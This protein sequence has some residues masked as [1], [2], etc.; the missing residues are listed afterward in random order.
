MIAAA[1][2]LVIVLS[3]GGHWF[4]G[5]PQ[6]IRIEW[7]VE[8]PIANAEFVWSLECEQTALATGRLAM[9][10]DRRP[11][12]LTM[13][14]PKVRVQTPMTLAYHVERKDS[15]KPLAEGTIA[16]QLYPEDLL[17]HTAKR[18]AGKRLFVWDR[19]D[20]LPT[21]LKRVAIEHTL[22]TRATQL[23]FASPGILIVGL[24]QLGSDTFDQSSLMSFAGAGTSVLVLNQTQPSSL[25]GYPLARRAAPSKLAWQET[26]SLSRALQRFEPS[27]T[28]SEL[29][30]I[31]LPADEPVLE[32]AWWPRE[33]PSP[34]PASIDALVATKAVGNGRLV[35]CQLPLGDWNADP[36][37]HLFLADALDYLASRAEATPSPSHRTRPPEPAPSPKT[38]TVL[39]P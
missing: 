24:D 26:H 29:W 6:T 30:A 13:A 16:V 28:S 18:M 32:V 4:G 39:I 20:G 19:S 7:N 17:T 36:R 9:P 11:A 2:L 27:N 14:I 37:N 34:K 22:I 10:V 38:S 1:T 12:V 35:L 25:A 5:T 23:Q 15:P 33:T 3:N 8:K 31:Q 21:L